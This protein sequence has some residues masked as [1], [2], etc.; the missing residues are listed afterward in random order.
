MPSLRHLP[1]EDR[2][3]ELKL[4]TVR[5]RVLRGDLIETFKILTGKINLDSTKFFERNTDDRTRGHHLKLKGK[6][7]THLARAK[8]FSHRVPSH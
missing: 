2:L 1:Y 8:F 7:A 4:L 5:N 6:R 3:R